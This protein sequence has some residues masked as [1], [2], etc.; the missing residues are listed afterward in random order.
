MTTLEKVN[1]SV[2]LR[3]SVSKSKTFGDCA[4]KYKFA[5]IEKLPQK[6]FSFHTF[7]KFVHKVL[8]DFH[9]EYINGSN[10]KFN[11]VMSKAFKAAK[12]EFKLANEMQ[13]EAYD[14]IDAYLKL[15]VINND[16]KKV[17]SVEKKFDFAISDKVVLNGMIDRIQLDDDGILHVADYKT[18]KNKKYLKNDWLQLLTYAYV[19]WSENQNIK[20]IRGSYILLRHN[21]EYITKD[22]SLEE[23]LEVKN[24][25]ETYAKQIEE[26][27]LWT[28]APTRLCEYCSYLDICDEGRAAVRPKISIGK[29]AW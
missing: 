17:I 26:E 25:Y 11:T 7:G 29:T 2:A 20:N 16:V 4:K 3:L 18:T 8:E 21:F 15:L 6:E 19:I 24:K 12:S 13:K 1:A 14:I 22:F 27:R 9:S 10:E 23:I 28:A 5:Y